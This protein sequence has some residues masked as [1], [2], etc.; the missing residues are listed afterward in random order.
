M[1]EFSV[2]DEKL[3]Y[4]CQTLHAVTDISIFLFDMEM[5]LLSSYS[6]WEKHMKNFFLLNCPFTPS[7]IVSTADDRLLYYSDSLHLNWYII[8]LPGQNLFFV[9]GPVFETTI[10]PAFF[11]KE[12]NFKSMSVSSQLTFLKMIRNIPIIPTVAFLQYAST[13]YYGVYQKLPDFSKTI[14]PHRQSNTPYPF[15]EKEEEKEMQK[16]PQ[17]YGLSLPEKLMIEGVMTGN[18]HLF[19]DFLKIPQTG[20]GTM[21]N[22]DP[23]RQAKN[24]TLAQITLVTRAAVAGGM[25]REASYS[26][27]DYYI[28][29]LELCTTVDDVRTLSLQMYQT[30]VQQVHEIQTKNLSPLS[31]YVCTYIA[32]HIREVI[33]LDAIASELGY[34]TYYLT[35]LFRKDV[36][37]TI[38]TY[39]LE[40]KIEQ[41]KIMLSSTLLDVQEISDSLSF[42]SPS[43]F[44][45]KFK[46]VTG[47]SPLSYRKKRHESTISRIILP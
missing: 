34:D 19:N 31:L 10:T 29:Q 40:Q 45:T 5:H 44:C 14:M 41:A 20:V 16:I 42:K 11:Q 46:K 13:V 43:Y 17:S 15:S 22:G 3:T 24:E 9:F 1:A 28:Q 26:Q 12:L 37:K 33:S 36:G 38:K 35:T 23:L 39:I 21:S 30:F 25:V 8:P 18:I 4:L 2:S 32:S 7:D 6:E 47:E 27:S